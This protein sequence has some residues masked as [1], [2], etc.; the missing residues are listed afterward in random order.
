V[1]IPKDKFDTALAALQASFF[2]NKELQSTLSLYHA[3]QLYG[4]STKT[5]PIFGH[6]SYLGYEND[7]WD[8]K[9]QL[10]LRP[11]AKFIEPGG[12]IKLAEEDEKWPNYWVYKFDGMTMKR[13]SLRKEYIDYESVEQLNTLFAKMGENLLKLGETPTSLKYTI[14]KLFIDSVLDD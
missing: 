1:K 5:D 9:T 7:S 12:V 6:I 11:L 10:V 8:Y 4:W 14:S 3:L 2:S 13:N